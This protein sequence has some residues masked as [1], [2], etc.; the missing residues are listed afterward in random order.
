[1]KKRIALILLFAIVLT[2][3]TSVPAEIES[4]LAQYEKV[5][6]QNSEILARNASNL[7][8]D[9]SGDLILIESKDQL[10]QLKLMANNRKITPKYNKQFFKN[11]VLL[12]CFVS[13]SSGAKV[14]E[15]TD[16][17]LRDGLVCPVFMIRQNEI[18]PANIHSTVVA[19][20]IKRT[21]VELT[22]G[23]ILTFNQDNLSYGAGYHTSLS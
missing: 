2:G 18:V 12:L 17:I 3:C 5:T 4:I 19:I 6:Y 21:D 13:H 1:M 10:D 20:E 16:V 7:E 9:I 11:N 14:T 8:T 23:E 15:L 22:P